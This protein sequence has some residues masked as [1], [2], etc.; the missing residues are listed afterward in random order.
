MKFTC[1]DCGQKISVDESRCGKTARCPSCSNKLTVPFPEEDYLEEEQVEEHEEEHE[2]DEHVE[3]EHVEDEHVDE[4]H[5][6][7][8]SFSE[9]SKRRS[10]RQ[11][12]GLFV[13]L[14]NMNPTDVKRIFLKVFIGFISVS[15][16]IAILAVLGS[17][18][19]EFML[20]VLATTTS[21]AAASICCMSCAAFIEKKRKVELGTVGIMFSA[22]AAV[23]VVSA[24]WLEIDHKSYWKLAGSFIILAVAFSH[25]FLLALPH[26]N[27]EHRWS[28]IASSIFISILTFQVLAAIWLEIDREGYWKLLA[29]VSILVVLLSLVIPVLMKIRTVAKTRTGVE[30]RSG[31]EDS[32]RTLVLHETQ[33]GAFVDTHGVIYSVTKK[34]TKQD[35]GDSA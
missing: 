26:L 21:I 19:G 25:A 13:Q 16:L 3:D 28:Q 7:E 11:R 23:M 31:V 22:M 9:S 14:R 10:D 17:D 6:E 12:G 20:K 30:I 8:R 24:I 15:A 4:E 32:L 35:S 29:V 27:R 1:D 34:S 33:D 2:E 18:P 5:L